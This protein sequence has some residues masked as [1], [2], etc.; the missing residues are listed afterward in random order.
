MCRPYNFYIVLWRLHL[1]A[2]LYHSF[3]TI[4]DPFRLDFFLECTQNIALDRFDLNTFQPYN[5]YTI[6]LECFLELGPWGNPC[7]SVGSSMV[8]IF[9]DNMASKTLVSVLPVKIH[10]G[11]LRNPFD[12]SLVETVL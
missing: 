11:S 2:F 1:D 8:D 5:W 10:L 3:Y 4:V 7:M 12:L 6:P 9:Q